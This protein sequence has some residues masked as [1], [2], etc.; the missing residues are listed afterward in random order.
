MK[1][2]RQCSTRRRQR[3]RVEPVQRRARDAHAAAPALVRGDARGGFGRREVVLRAHHEVEQLGVAARV[4]HLH[5]KHSRA[6]S[7]L[8]SGARCI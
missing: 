2:R 5:A 8:C 1:S 6:A 3:R 4:L 7:P